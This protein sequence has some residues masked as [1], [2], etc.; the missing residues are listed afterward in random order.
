MALI[1]SLRDLGTCIVPTTFPEGEGCRLGYVRWSLCSGHFH[2]SHSEDPRENPR[3]ETLPVHLGSDQWGVAILRQK[4]ND[5][6]WVKCATSA[7]E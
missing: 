7:E 3:S 1:F 6:S 4:G 5:D 2:H